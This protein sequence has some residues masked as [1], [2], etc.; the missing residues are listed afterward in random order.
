MEH[1]HFDTATERPMHRVRVTRRSVMSVLGAGTLAAVMAA[2]GGA[3]APTAAPAPKPTEPPKVAEPTK[4]AAAAPTTAPAAAPTTAPAAAAT[5]A[6]AA[7]PTTAPAAKPTE[8]AKPAAGTAPEGGTLVI[9][10][11]QEPESLNP[12]ITNMTYSIWVNQIINTEMIKTAKDD[13]LTPNLVQEVPTLENG[14]ISK[15]GLTYTLKFKPNLKWSD[16]NPLTGDDLVMTHKLIT[17]PKFG[18]GS[19]IGWEKISQIE[20]SADKLT[21][22]IRLKEVWVSF[23]Y[24]CLTYAASSGG[25]FL[26]PA[27][28]FKSIPVEKI[29]EDPSG[30]PGGNK[31][32]GAGPYKIVEWKKNQSLTV[33]RNPNW[34]GT[35][36]KLDRIIY[37]FVATREAEMDGLR[38][39]DLD[40]GVDF[41]EAQIPDLEKIAEAKVF[42]SKAVGTIERYYF[43]LYDPGSDRTKPHRLWGGVKEGAK[44]R[45][46]MAMGM[47]R[48][49]IVDKILY[50]KTT[51]A[52]NEMDNNAQ[53]NTASLK[54]YPFDLDKAAALLEEAGWKKGA[55]GI[56]EKGGVKSEFTHATTSGNV[57][58]ETIQRAI[59]ADLEK[60]GIRMKIENYKP[61][62]MFANYANSG[63][64]ATG[65]TD[66]W[67]WTTGSTD[68]STYDDLLGSKNIPTKEKPDG[69][70]YVGYKDADMDTL[71]TQQS[72]AVDPKERK[73]IVDKIHQKLYDDVP[74]LYVY[75]RLNIDVAKTWVVG[76]EPYPAARFFW[77]VPDWG[78]TRKK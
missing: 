74:I 49:A 68:P 19:T 22:T 13:K 41:V 5:T 54:P 45:L 73:A 63:I 66:M 46:A 28:Y 33:E 78:T 67:G 40:Y 37:N 65:K 60:I 56:R 30:A 2:C 50:G 36:P 72:K 10:M 14:G 77:N 76:V 71:L 39:G 31:Y 58:R 11:W 61:S 34:L 32:I 24:D 20:L 6:P 75:N 27:H 29:A 69:N 57:T 43:N 15:D 55:D 26:L 52:V 70:N 47:N 35:K 23:L 42:P 59:L 51:V 4:P 44:V 64:G 16:G 25:G 17:D 62:E 38:T 18:A 9:G 1:E 7:A 21:A 8:A 3:P 48:Q 53:W 12:Y